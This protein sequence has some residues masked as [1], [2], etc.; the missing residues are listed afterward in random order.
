MATS[1]PL[2][3][4]IT[5]ARDSRDN[6]GVELSGLRRAQ[7]EA[8]TQLDTLLQYR[9]EY[10][11]QLQAAMETGI[12][13]DRWGNYQQFLRSLDEAIAR[14]RQV[15]AERES[16]L[17]QGQQRWQSE[18]RRLNAYDTLVDRRECAERQR[19]SRREQRLADEMSAGMRLRRQAHTAH[20]G[21]NH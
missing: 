7:Q 6:A 18:Q 19:V 9:H 16:R 8:R 10:R 5:L 2:D 11:Q 4:L 3:T 20:S 14:S 13:P 1:T 12:G 17:A 15:L 21:S